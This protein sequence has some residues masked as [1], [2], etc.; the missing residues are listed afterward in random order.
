MYGAK[1]KLEASFPIVIPL[2]VQIILPVITKIIFP[3]EEKDCWSEYSMEMDGFSCFFEVPFK[4]L[5]PNRL[6]K[7]LQ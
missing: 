2:I 4:E 1:A 3:V 7:A 5:V 6:S